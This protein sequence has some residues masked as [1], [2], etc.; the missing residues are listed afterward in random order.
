VPLPFRDAAFSL[1]VTRYSFHHF[2]DPQAVLAE[3]VRVCA[4]GGRV[5]VIDVFT[6]TPE[7]AEAYNRPRESAFQ[8]FGA[9]L[10]CEVGGRTLDHPGQEL[11]GTTIEV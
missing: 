3:M 9:R 1:V 7:E 6:S 8:P 11:A 4:P 5:A 10:G 2:L